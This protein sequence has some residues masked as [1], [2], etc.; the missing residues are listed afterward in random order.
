MSQPDPLDPREVARR[1][2]DILGQ[3]GYVAKDP[4]APAGTMANP[5]GGGLSLLA[6]GLSLGALLFWPLAAMS[7]MLSVSEL[8]RPDGAVRRYWY[9]LVGAYVVSTWC[10]ILLA[11]SFVKVGEY[12]Y[13]GL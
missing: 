6:F 2:E 12:S 9:L 11:V 5:R 4:T 7:L 8:V 1:A 10:L 13:L 3:L